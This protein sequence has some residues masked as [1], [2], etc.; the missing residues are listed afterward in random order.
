M[1]TKALLLILFLALIVSN[2]A[3]SVE[4]TSEYMEQT[5][6]RYLYNQNDVIDVFYEDN[7]LFLNWMDV[8]IIE[9][10]VIDKHTFF[11]VDIYKKMHFVQHPET[12][13]RYLSIVSEDNEDLIAYDYLKVDDTFTTPSMHL[14]NK[15]YDKALAGYLEIKEKDSTNFT[16]DE[17]DL[18]N[19]GY[20]LLRK[21]EYVNAIDVLKMNVALYPESANVYDSLGEAFLKSG[22]SIEAFNN[23]QKAYEYNHDNERA[24]R[25]MDS[26]KST[27]N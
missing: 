9:P 2:C 21:K 8:K 25:F 1:K 10:V 13:E 17:G 14:Q 12:K 4:Y 19:L 5:S 16:L 11:V 18:N 7:K 6:G 20:E 15:D 22:D 24:K 3:K 27:H 26:Y 23:Y